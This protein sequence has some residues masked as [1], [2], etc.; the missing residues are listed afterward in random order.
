VIAGAL[1]IGL[2]DQTGYEQRLDGI[3]AT[4]LE[5]LNQ[6]NSRA[7]SPNEIAESLA[8]SVTGAP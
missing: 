5:V 1:E 4:T 7:L 2:I 6:A 3:Y 8:D